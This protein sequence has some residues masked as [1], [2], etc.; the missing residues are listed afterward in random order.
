MEGEAQYFKKRLLTF[1]GTNS[2]LMITPIS[3]DKP[4]EITQKRDSGWGCSF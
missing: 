3:K 4:N 2:K 1:N